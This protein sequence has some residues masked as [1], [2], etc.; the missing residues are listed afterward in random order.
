MIQTSCQTHAKYIGDGRPEWNRKAR[1]KSYK[2]RGW[3]KSILKWMGS[4]QSPNKGCEGGGKI[5]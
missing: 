5:R 4:C 3:L 2:K 1:R